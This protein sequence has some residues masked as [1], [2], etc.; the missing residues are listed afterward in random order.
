VKVSG[1][2]VTAK[3]TVRN[4]GERAGTAVPQFYLTGPNGANILLRLVGWDRVD[5]KAG[6]Q[7][8]VAVSIDPRLLA[9]FDENARRWRIRA[10]AYQVSAGFESQHRE[11]NATFELQPASL[12]P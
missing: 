6:E 4:S 12:P 11:S 7:R 1:H 10:G 2:T 3:A 5:L 9:T 8:Q